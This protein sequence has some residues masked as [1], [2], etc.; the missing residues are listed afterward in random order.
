[1]KTLIQKCLI[2]VTPHN[3]YDHVLTGQ[4]NRPLKFAEQFYNHNLFSNLLIV[5]RLRPS[6]IFFIKESC[7]QLLIKGVL[8]NLFFDKKNQVYYMEHCIPFGKL[9]ETIL[10]WII[11]YILKKIKQKNYFLWVCD[12]KSAGLMLKLKSINNLFDAYD[13]WS[14]S[15]FYNKKKRHMKYINRGYLIAKN[16]AKLIITNTIHMKEKLLTKT[17][18]IELISNTSSL[19]IEDKDTNQHNDNKIVGYIGNIH[20]RLDL[21]LIKSIAEHFP[22]VKFIFIGKNNYQ[23][24]Y[25]EKLVNNCSNIDFIG[26]RDYKEIPSYIEKFD[27]GI[28]PH[29]VNEYTLSQD[30]MKIYDYLAYGK[31]IVATKIPPA[32]I[33]AE[34][35][36]VGNTKKQFIEKLDQALCENNDELKNRRLIFMKKN[37]WRKKAE[38]ICKLLED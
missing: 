36:Y 23:S 8:F 5:N 22:N 13:D 14:L 34:I 18:K 20:E 25:F 24:N 19:K 32:D 37:T 33:L 1:M 17:N 16:N 2:Y 30:S 11:K 15:P 6:R 7:R 29:L 31:P 21:D 12:P 10:P 3:W 26:P 38:Y 4:I 28:V 9:E 35:I 27:V